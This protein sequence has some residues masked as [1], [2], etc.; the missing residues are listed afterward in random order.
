MLSLVLLSGFVVPAQQ[1]VSHAND[2]GVSAVMENIYPPSSVTP[3]CHASTLVALKDGDLLA[4]WFGGAHERAPD[5]AIYTA[6]FHQSHW[7]TPIEVARE[8]D[9]DKGLPTW[10]PVLFHTDDG[11]LWLYYKSG[12]SPSTWTATRLVSTDEGKTWSSKERLPEGIL[13]PIRAK[14]LVLPH[15]LIVSGSSTEGNGGWRVWIERSTDDGKSWTRIGPLLMTAATDSSATP[16]PEPDLNSPEL[17]SKD[18]GPRTY[19]GIIQPSVV[20]LGPKHL[21][22]YARSK[23]LTSRAV[24][25]DS[26]DGGLTWT[27][28][29]FLAVPNNNSGLDAIAL[30]D[31]RIVMICNWTPRGRSPLN[32][33]VSTDG[34]HFRVFATLEQG[35]GEYSYPAIIQGSDGALEMTW[36]WHRTT[37]R[38]AH[39]DLSKVPS[40]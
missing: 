1:A 23:T 39:L 14:P 35:S 13:G 40:H 2:R 15:G 6:R 21:R 25:A 31:G 12:P 38:H 10:N 17:R 7:S 3:E 34:E 33:A 9:G 26:Y 30:K 37:I 18:K 36:T 27:A 11:R 4:S 28:P 24:A 32:L 16:W 22:L 8:R 5:V 29:H 19:S 20:Q